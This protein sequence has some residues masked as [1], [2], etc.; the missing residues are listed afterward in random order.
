[1][2][3]EEQFNL[4]NFGANQDMDLLPGLREMQI[5]GEVVGDGV[6]L[7]EDYFAADFTSD[8]EDEELGGTYAADFTDNE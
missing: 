6:A 7:Q 1:M 3:I 4:T 5:G 2:T 8:S